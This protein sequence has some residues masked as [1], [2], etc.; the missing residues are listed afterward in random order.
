MQ[1]MKKLKIEVP[2]DPAIS[3]LGISPKELKAGSQRDIYRPM[4]IASLSTI[5]KKLKESKCPTTDK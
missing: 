2:H 5:A 1:F 3:F 4:V